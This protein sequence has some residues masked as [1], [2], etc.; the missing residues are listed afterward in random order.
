M[1]AAVEVLRPEYMK[2]EMLYAI[3]DFDRYVVFIWSMLDRIMAG[4]MTKD[5]AEELSTN[6]YPEVMFIRKYGLLL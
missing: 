6:E 5:M 2:V 1:V 4:A 3:I